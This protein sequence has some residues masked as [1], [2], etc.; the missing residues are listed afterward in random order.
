MRAMEAVIGA[1]LLVAYRNCWMLLV[2]LSAAVVLE[3]TLEMKLCL[4]A[5][6]L[7]DLLLL[8]FATSEN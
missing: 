3:T 2:L 6:S 4:S 1:G 7:L 5:R 8:Y